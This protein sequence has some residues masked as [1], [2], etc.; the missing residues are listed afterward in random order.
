VS[1]QV[2]VEKARQVGATAATEE[3]EAVA[4]VEATLELRGFQALVSH[5][6]EEITEARV[7]GRGDRVWLAA[8][9]N[10]LD[11]AQHRAA[12]A[13]RALQDKLTRWEKTYR[14]ERWR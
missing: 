5:L 13:Q 10:K 8:M 4:V 12:D 11:H 2:V 3:A 1:G 7:R 14:P 6:D 9:Q